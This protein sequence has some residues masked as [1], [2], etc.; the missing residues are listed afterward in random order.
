MAAKCPSQWR[1]GL[2]M[3]SGVAFLVLLLIGIRKNTMVMSKVA[4]VRNRVNG[5]PV[6][7]GMAARGSRRPILR[8]FEGVRPSVKGFS[9]EQTDEEYYYSSEYEEMDMEEIQEL[10]KESYIPTNLN[11]PNLEPMYGDPPV[12]VAR[13]F[14]SL[15]DCDGLVE[16][17]DGSGFLKVSE[18]KG[19]YGDGAGIIGENNEALRTSSSLFLEDDRI[20][21]IPEAKAIYD[22]FIENLRKLF[23]MEDKEWANI[24]CNTQVARYYPGEYFRPHWDAFPEAYME[25]VGAQRMVTVLVYLN[26]VDVGGGTYFP[27]LDIRSL[28]EK[29]KALIFYP[30]DTTFESDLRTQHEAEDAVDE[31]WVAQIWLEFPVTSAAMA[32][33][34]LKS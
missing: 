11:Y 16:A 29:G 31:K 28:P 32:K 10:M 2:S 22:R 7:R 21:A 33:V 5:G 18:V 3:A 19:S 27:Q 8:R 15:D 25:K 1:R 30:A 20:Q 17:V 34:Q 13:S 6:R 23:P 14:M 4:L 9:M 26:D 12:F 24:R